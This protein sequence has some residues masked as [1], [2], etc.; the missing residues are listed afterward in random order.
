MPD[1]LADRAAIE[2]VITLYSEAV[3]SRKFELF[4]NVFLPYTIFDYTT[5]GVIGSL[6]EFRAQLIPRMAETDLTQH[7]VTNLRISFNG[8]AA[9]STCYLI[10]QHVV[11]A[12]TPH[13]KLMVG[14]RYTDDWARIERGWRIARRKAEGL[15]ATG[16]P[17][18]LG[19]ETFLGLASPDQP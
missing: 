3:D 7:F 2:D 15:W 4:D 16:N 18:V 11:T 14:G 6:A 1:K 9:Q 19:V 12:L 17:R 8:D 5:S 13:D 10:A